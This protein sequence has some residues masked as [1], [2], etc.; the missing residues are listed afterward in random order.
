MLP[1]LPEA[2]PGCRAD[3]NERLYS[4]TQVAPLPLLPSF[5]GDLDAP[6]QVG[7]HPSCHFV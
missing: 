7:M 1:M 6:F 4:V 3:P 5:F 2:V